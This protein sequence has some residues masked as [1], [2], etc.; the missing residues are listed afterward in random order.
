MKHGDTRK[1]DETGMRDKMKTEQMIQK[2]EGKL[3]EMRQ[4]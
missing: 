1:N 3:D 4:A 2:K